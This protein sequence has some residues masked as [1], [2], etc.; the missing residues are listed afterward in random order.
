M[1][2][3]NS[4]ALVPEFYSTLHCALLL[5]DSIFTLLSSPFIESRVLVIYEEITIRPNIV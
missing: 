4:S 3:L 1:K 5:E 2:G